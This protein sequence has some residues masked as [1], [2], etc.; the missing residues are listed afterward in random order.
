ML[1]RVKILKE[2]D[3]FKTYSFNKFRY[4][5]SVRLIFV[6]PI[7]HSTIG[8]GEYSSVIAKWKGRKD[9]LKL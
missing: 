6:R 3:E 9:F 2:Y 5:T 7:L 1:Y 8:K 4:Y